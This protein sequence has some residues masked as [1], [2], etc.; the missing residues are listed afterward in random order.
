[1]RSSKILIALLPVLLALPFAAPAAAAT[2]ASVTMYAYVVLWDIVPGQS[3]A[4]ETQLHRGAMAMASDRSFHSERLL[5]NIDPLTYSEATY[6]KSTNRATLEQEMSTRIAALRPYLRRAPETHLALVS[7]SYRKGSTSNQ[8]TP[9]ELGS[10]GAGQIAHLGLFIPYPDFVAEYQRTL[11]HVKVYTRDRYPQ[12]YLGEDVLLEA[13]LVSPELQTP[14][15][16]HAEKAA[17]M[18]LNYGEYQTLE[19]AENSY[20]KRGADRPKD[21]QILTWE[22]IFYG[23]LQVP[24]RFYIYQVVSSVSGPA[25]ANAAGGGAKGAR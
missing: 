4:F 19:D 25:M 7:Q 14:Y 3:E 6:T 5:R 24:T 11:D 12:G 15:T 23:A 21:P 2:E 8:P 13:D 9:T 22:R 17:K 18:S 10:T 20:I 1:M 16:P